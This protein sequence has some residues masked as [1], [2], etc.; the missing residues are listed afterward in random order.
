MN[1]YEGPK[2]FAKKEIVA[3]KEHRC[4]ECRRK[5]W[6]GEPYI[7]AKG[8]WDDW[9]DFKTCLVCEHV[10][11]L[12]DEHVYT[13]LRDTLRDECGSL[14]LMAVRLGILEERAP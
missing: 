10:S 5:I 3:R 2:V 4:C 1:D 8:L 11:N 7:M 14:E 9:M 12:I 13:M 6:P